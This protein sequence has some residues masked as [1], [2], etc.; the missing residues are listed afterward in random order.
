MVVLRIVG[1]DL[2]LKV[3]GGGGR[4]AHEGGKVPRKTRWS[5]G[6]GDGEERERGGS[7]TDQEARSGNSVELRPEE[8]VGARRGEELKGS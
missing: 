4:A 1:H 5:R 7:G 8:E 2:R 6:R 3:V